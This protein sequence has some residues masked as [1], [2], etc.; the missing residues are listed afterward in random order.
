MKRKYLLSILVLLLGVVLVSCKKDPIPEED[1][2]PVILPEVTLKE[3]RFKDNLSNFEFDLDDFHIGL[4]ELEKVYSD[5]SKQYVQVTYDMISNEDFEMLF[6]T[7][8]F[9]T[10]I[11]YSNKSYYAVVNLNSDTPQTR[12]AKTYIYFVKTKNGNNYEYTFYSG[13]NENFVSFELDLTLDKSSVDVELVEHQGGLFNYQ[14]TGNNIQIMY[15]LGKEIKGNNKLFTITSTE[16]I[17]LNINSKNS[18][19]LKL[20]ET[21]VVVE[22][23][24]RFYKR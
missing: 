21:D 6:L 13:G 16:D 7:G 5:N 8:S 4:I 3:I 2:D 15:S 1:D 20:L 18:T 12:H 22:E 23:D 14:Q 10:T 9:L 17:D 24:V 11:N 19:V